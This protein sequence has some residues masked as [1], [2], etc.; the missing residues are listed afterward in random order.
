[1]CLFWYSNKFLLLLLQIIGA[2]LCRFIHYLIL[3]DT[4]QTD[5]QSSSQNAQWHGAC[6][7]D[8]K[9]Q[10]DLQLQLFSL[11]SHIVT[12]MFTEPA[13]IHKICFTRQLSDVIHHDVLIPPS[14]YLQHFFSN[15]H[16]T[17]SISV[18][19]SFLDQMYP[20]NLVNS[21]Q[22]LLLSYAHIDLV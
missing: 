13:A 19:E 15:C 9:L 2:Y 5:S 16:F 18:S 8:S 7:V 11:S 20:P 6:V 10:N 3:V 14:S 22:L 17:L 21:L 4:C 12:L 1:M